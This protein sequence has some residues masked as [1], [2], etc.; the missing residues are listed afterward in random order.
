MPIG[1]SWPLA[2]DAQQQPTLPVIGLAAAYVAVVHYVVHYVVRSDMSCITSSDPICR[3]LR[4]CNFWKRQGWLLHQSCS[5][6]KV[7]QLET[8]PDFKPIV[9]QRVRCADEPWVKASGTT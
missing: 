2:A 8:V 3:A 4:R 7:S 1:V 9:N 5:V 6:R